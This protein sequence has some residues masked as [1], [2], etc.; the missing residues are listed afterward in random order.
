MY[1]K[2]HNKGCFCQKGEKIMKLW[3]VIFQK[4][5]NL[6]TLQR[7][8]MAAYSKS[9]PLNVITL[10]AIMCGTPWAEQFLWV[11]IFAL[12][13]F[14]C[15]FLLFEASNSLLFQMSLIR[16]KYY[17]LSTYPMIDFGAVQVGFFFKASIALN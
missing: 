9:S 13:R 1:L 7:I 17:N 10:L 8:R 16:R 3:K 14:Y 5:R 11:F 6:P 15:I 2:K 4:S 12:L